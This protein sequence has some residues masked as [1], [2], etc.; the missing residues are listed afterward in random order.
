MARFVRFIGDTA[1][2]KTF[3]I[4]DNQR[5]HLQCYGLLLY[6]GESANNMTV[7]LRRS[8][9]FKR[10]RAGNLESKDK[11][12]SDGNGSHR[13]QRASKTHVD[14]KDDRLSIIAKLALLSMRLERCS[15]L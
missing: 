1:S 9:A 8:F 4:M 11:D 13:S 6:K 7:E 14:F 5:K 2:F 10:F 15:L 3:F 12:C